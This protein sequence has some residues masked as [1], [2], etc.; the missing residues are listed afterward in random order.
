MGRPGL[1][2][3][4]ALLL[5]G[6]EAPPIVPGESSSFGD[7]ANLHV[8]V[9]GGYRE[10]DLDL[11]EEHPVVGLEVF[12]S[13]PRTGGWGFELGGRYGYG[14][15]E[16]GPTVETDFYELGLGVRQT[17]GSEEDRLRP[18]VGVGAAWTKTEQE[19]QRL[20][21]FPGGDEVPESFDERDIAA[22][23]HSGALWRIPLDRTTGI[24]FGLDLRGLWGE[25]LAY[26]ELG[27]AVG[28]GQ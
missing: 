1:W 15:E 20:P 23:L 18:F 5:A 11:V 2:S 27:I 12:T 6:C 21:D 4:L 8:L 19:A 25:D 26:V 13:D 14:E 24:V 22:Y 10:N 9:L 7:R 16:P 28:I 3:T 17:F